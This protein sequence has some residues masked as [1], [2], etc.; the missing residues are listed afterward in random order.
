MA[1]RTVTYPTAAP[2]VP[3]RGSLRALEE[4]ARSCTGCPLFERATQTVFGAGDESARVLLVGE[5]PGDA[6]DQQGRPFVGPAGALLDRALADAGI[7]RA[8][9][10]ITNAVKHFSWE[11][12]GKRRIHK[13]P[14]LS[15][16]K[17]CQPW[18]EAEIEAV[19]P[20]VI[21]CLG[22]TAV[23]AVLGPSVKITEMRGRALATPRGRVV[24]ARHPS[25][26]LRM[27]SADER[28]IG[29]EELVDD[30]KLAAR[31]AKAESAAP[32]KP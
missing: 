27:M 17:A 21:V 4:A 22:A 28:R 32:S 18:L 14:R 2:F 19:R 11:P 29:F 6:E 31:L 13:K 12:R 25:A 5:Q 9:A 7:P 10:Y 1:K 24:V 20:R 15:E 23:Q 3:E 30:L 8:E 16:I 26:I